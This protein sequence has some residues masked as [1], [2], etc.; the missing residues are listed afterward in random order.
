MSRFVSILLAADYI[1]VATE[2]KID[3]MVANSKLMKLWE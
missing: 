3:S 1:F 2:K